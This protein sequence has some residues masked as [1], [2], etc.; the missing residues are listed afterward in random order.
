MSDQLSAI[1]FQPADRC[2]LIA[3]GFYMRD[4]IRESSGRSP[5]VNN[6]AVPAA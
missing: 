3:E 5:R 4:G 6:P 2:S 1:S